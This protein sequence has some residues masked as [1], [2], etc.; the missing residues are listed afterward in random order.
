MQLKVIL[1]YILIF[2]FNLVEKERKFQY[3]FVI[4]ASKYC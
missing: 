2:L 1:K 4:A 3:S